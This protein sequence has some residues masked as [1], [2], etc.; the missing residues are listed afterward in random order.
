MKRGSRLVEEN[1]KL[2][3][4][5]FLYD[6]RTGEHRLGVDI[7]EADR[8]R[9]AIV[10]HVEHAPTRSQGKT[11][12]EM[13][14]DERKGLAESDPTTFKALVAEAHFAAVLVLSPED[15][16]GLV[17]RAR[18]E[19]EAREARLSAYLATPPELLVKTIEAIEFA[20]VR[21]IESLAHQAKAQA[22]A[23]ARNQEREVLGRARDDDA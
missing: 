22:I 13:S 18:G 23:A 9:A 8:T 12:G 7:P 6:P 5:V 17:A 3:K 19:E 16:A 14:N 20:P 21:T 11:Y 10:D 1:R 15:V 2:G 4:R